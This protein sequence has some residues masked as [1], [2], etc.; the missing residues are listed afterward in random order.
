MDSD[1]YKYYCCEIC[2]MACEDNQILLTCEPLYLYKR[3]LF[4]E[5]FYSNVLSGCLYGFCV[6]LST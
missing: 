2:D 5:S 4:V 3:Q 6:F 1:A